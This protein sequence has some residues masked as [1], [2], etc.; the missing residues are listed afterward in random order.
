MTG[1][2]CVSECGVEADS[3]EAGADNE[4][5]IAVVRGVGVN[6]V[7]Q[8]ACETT[9]LAIGMSIDLSNTSGA[10][11]AKPDRRT[12]GRNPIDHLLTWGPV[13]LYVWGV[14]LAWCGSKVVCWRGYASQRQPVK[15]TAGGEEDR[16]LGTEAIVRMGRASG[17]NTAAGKAEAQYT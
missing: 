4:A 9:S 2:E 12:A 3:V 17:N 15:V 5:Q 6:M 14:R 13:Y 7:Y 10:V 11:G 16:P 8:P 1:V